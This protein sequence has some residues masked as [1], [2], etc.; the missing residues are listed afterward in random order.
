VNTNMA[1]FREWMSIKINQAL[2]LL[3]KIVLIV[4]SKSGIRNH[5]GNSIVWGKIQ[6][7]RVETK[8]PY[9]PI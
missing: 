1:A 5:Y 3:C 8:S 6:V 2:K 9:Q 7:E 4:D